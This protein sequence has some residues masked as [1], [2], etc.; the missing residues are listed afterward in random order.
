MDHTVNPSA[1]DDAE[2]HDQAYQMR[3]Y[4]NIPPG[5]EIADPHPSAPFQQA[6]SFLQTLFAQSTTEMPISTIPSY[7]QS[8]GEG[9]DPTPY[10]PGFPNQTLPLSY[11]NPERGRRISSHGRT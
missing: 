10:A 3:Q 6:E 8:Q 1:H 9:S 11:P 4:F 2:Q 5:A 7:V